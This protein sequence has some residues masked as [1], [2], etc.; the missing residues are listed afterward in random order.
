MNFRRSV[1][2][3]ELWH[4]LN[5]QDVGKK[6]FFAFLSDPLRENFQNSA[7]KDSSEHRSTCC[8]QISWNLA[9]GKSVKSCV[10]YL[11]KTETK[12]RLT[13]QSLPGPAPDSVL[14]VLH[15]SSK[16]VYFL[17]SYKLSERVNTVR[18]RSEVNAIFGWSIASS[19]V[20]ILRVLTNFKT[21]YEF[22]FVFTGQNLNRSVYTNCSVLTVAL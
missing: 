1:V 15:I 13:L 7:R 16:A 21:A 5:S 10:I 12:F 22:Y 17:R 2:I 8:L 9:V 6:Y 4:D 19:R 14:R 3:V 11:T 18:G 20:K